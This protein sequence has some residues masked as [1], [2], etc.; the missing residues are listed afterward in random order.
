MIFLWGLMEDLPLAAVRNELTQ[1]GRRIVFMNQADI[2]DCHIDIEFAPHLRGRIV[3]PDQTIRLEEI[4]AAYLRP[5][6]FRQ[7]PQL[8]GCA[9]DSEEWRHAMTFEDILLSWLDLAYALIL[10]RPSAM[11]SNNSKPYQTRLIEQSG[12][13]TPE[14]LITTSADSVRQFI[15]INN[16]IIY[17]SISAVRSIVSNISE[18][19]MKDI[20]DV[21]WCPT[22][23]QKL[24][25]GT[26]YRV[27]IIGDNIFS[28][29]IHSTGIDYRYHRS[30]IEPCEIP[31][32]VAMQCKSL[33]KQLMLPFCGIDLKRTP[34]DEWYC[35]EVNPSPAY[36]CYE[37]AT[38]Q[39]MTAAIA[40]LLTEA[41]KQHSVK[42]SL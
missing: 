32:E 9:P 36:I 6:D 2:L 18:Q 12:L 8:S 28:S 39:N 16:N 25:D 5:Y 11:A 13:V 17:K 15:K 38:G 35:F 37:N 19:R 34:Q 21:K 4:D 14:T 20:S 30:H 23:F 27:H 7:L 22:Q 42:S 33:S 3:T 31:S 26:D 41:T 40:E 24:V 10:N 29:R 1:N